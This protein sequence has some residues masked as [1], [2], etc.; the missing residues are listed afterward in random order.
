MNEGRESRKCRT[1]RSVSA[2]SLLSRSLDN[3]ALP[4]KSWKR[5]FEA[6]IR[7]DPQPETFL[8]E[9]RAEEQAREGEHAMHKGE[10]LLQLL[11]ISD[12][13]SRLHFTGLLG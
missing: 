3:T 9:I 10:L 5:A 12:A 8:F 1:R 13:S 2:R 7:R 11:L 4:V 6:R